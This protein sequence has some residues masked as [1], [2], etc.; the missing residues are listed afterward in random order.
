VSVR[1]HVPIFY[2]S[3]R[4]EDEIVADN[5]ATI[6][7]C[8]GVIMSQYPDLRKMLFDKKGR[9]QTWVGI[10]LNGEDAFPNEL[11]RPVRDGDEIRLFLYLSV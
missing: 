8:I 4:N 9:L 3:D 11:R 2:R 7:D 5:C 1:I 6:A 10:Y